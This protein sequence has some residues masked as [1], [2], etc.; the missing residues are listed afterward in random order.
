M[1]LPVIVDYITA[2]VNQYATH[3]QLVLDSAKIH[4]STTG[5]GV[6]SFHNF[7]LVDVTAMAS[8]E[9][10]TRLSMLRVCKSDPCLTSFTLACDPTVVKAERQIG[11]HKLTMGSL[12]GDLNTSQQE[13]LVV[14]MRELV[15]EGLEQLGCGE[16]LMDPIYSRCHK[17]INGKLTMSVP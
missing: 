8:K 10:E 2:K 13:K 3:Q 4:L 16:F 9:V 11:M 1:W 12:A 7:A 14:V 17:A 15:K 6:R 5:A